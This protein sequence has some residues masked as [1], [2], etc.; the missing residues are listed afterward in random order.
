VPTWLRLHI[1]AFAALGGVPRTVVPDNLKAAVIR[2]AF[3]ADRDELS[4]QKSYR[5]LARHF[6]FVIDPA[7]PRRHEHKGK[8]EASVK[9]LK[10]NFLLGSKGKGLRSTKES[11]LPHVRADYR[12]RGRDFWEERAGHLGDEVHRYITAVFDSDKQARQLR[13]VQSI[14]THLESFP[15]ARAQAACHRALHYG[16]FTLRGIKDIL[17]LALDLLPLS[18]AQSPHPPDSPTGNEG[19]SSAAPTPT[20]ARPIASLL[21]TKE[22]SHDWI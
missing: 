20:F 14:V 19:T 12:H 4:I 5:E 1:E 9:Y 6:G 7:P 18:S 11:H 8:V 2:A 10:R 16:C 21:P 3:G 15:A 13:A 22:D 17:R